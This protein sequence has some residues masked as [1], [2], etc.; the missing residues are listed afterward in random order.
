[1]AQHNRKNKNP[2]LFTLARVCGTH[3]RS[4]IFRKFWRLFHPL[5]ELT[6][7]MAVLAMLSLILGAGIGEDCNKGS[8]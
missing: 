6:L 3:D 5:L 1:V 7:Y 2:S 4:S 8:W